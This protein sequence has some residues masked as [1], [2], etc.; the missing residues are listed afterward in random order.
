MKQLLLLSI[1]TVPLVAQEQTGEQLFTINCSACHALDRMTVGPSMVEM[2]KIY[3]GKPKDF[4]KWCK[5]PQQKRPGTIEMPSMSH[6]GDENLR[7][8]YEYLMKATEGKEEVVV[9][10]EDRYAIPDASLKRPTVQRMFMPNASPAA[11]A[12]ALPGDLSYCFDAGECRLRYVWKGGFIDGWPYW[13]SNG[14]SLAQIMG[15]VTYT[16]AA[17]PIS[18]M[19]KDMP[20]PPKFLGYSVDKDSLPTFRYNRLGFNWTETIKPLSDGTGIVRHF[21]SDAPVTLNVMDQEGAEITSST[22]STQIS[23]DQAKEFTLTVRWK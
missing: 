7:K 9:K 1:L 3:N 15:E 8:I 17:F 20:P 16:E 14:S 11:I 19:T 13:R 21:T 5:E 22:G 4:I 2:A 18:K 10:G 23:A 6:V 12:V